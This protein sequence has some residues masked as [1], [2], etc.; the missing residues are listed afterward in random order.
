MGNYNI[1][2]PYLMKLL[3]LRNA[4]TEKFTFVTGV[5]TQSKGLF[6]LFSWYMLGADPKE[7]RI[8]K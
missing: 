7:W 8:A 4:R 2:Y 3:L 5:Q 1:Y 6:C